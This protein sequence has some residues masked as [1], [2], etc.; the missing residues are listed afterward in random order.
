MFSNNPLFAFRK[1]K[2][3]E[4]QLIARNLIA[5]MTKLCATSMKPMNF[6][7]R[8]S[9]QFHTMDFWCA[10]VTFI[11]TA[12]MVKSL[13][14]LFFC[15]FREFKALEKVQKIAS[16]AGLWK[17]WIYSWSSEFNFWWP[18][19]Q[20]R[21]LAMACCFLLSFQ[22]LLWRNNQYDLKNLFRSRYQCNLS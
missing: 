15:R 10:K 8:K 4:F 17:N 13:K 22:I 19:F 18:W 21:W 2:R 7:N 5:K 14:K 11:I 12:K 3:R 9:V 16:R 20:T 1:K 6:Q